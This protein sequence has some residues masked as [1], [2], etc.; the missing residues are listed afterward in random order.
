MKDSDMNHLLTPAQK[1]ANKRDAKKRAMLEDIGSTLN[2]KPVKE[3]RKRKP[4][5]EEQRIAAVER[6]AKARANRPPPKNSSVH[7]DVLALPDDHPVSYVKVKEWLKF[8]KENRK[9]IKHQA[10]SKDSKE[11]SEF[12]ENEAYI[13]NLAIYIKD[14]VWLDYRYGKNGEGRTTQVCYTL[15]YDANGNP[16]R[17]IGTYYPD[18]GMMWTE[19]VRDEMN[20]ESQST[21]GYY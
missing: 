18:I 9:A 21:S 7:P 10:I 15:A 5:S 6:L 1:R 11:R 2:L 3:K 17:D 12:Q 8:A 16:K 4:M 14:G 13:K 19:E 20:N